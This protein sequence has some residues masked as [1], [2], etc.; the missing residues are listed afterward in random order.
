MSPTVSGARISEGQKPSPS[1]SESANAPKAPS[2]YS[3]PC[4]K[5]T[6]RSMPKITASPRLSSA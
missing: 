5:F 2:M 6:I 3:A 4:A 1:S